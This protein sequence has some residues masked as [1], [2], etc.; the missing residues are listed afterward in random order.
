MAQLTTALT[1]A[2]PGDVIVLANGTYNGA[3]AVSRNGTAANPVY[4]RGQNRDGVIINAT[5]ATYG[6]S[7]RGANV[8]IENLTI[9]DSSWGML[10]QDTNNVVVRGL[11]IMGTT[12][13]IDARAGVNRNYTICD[14]LLEGTARIWPDNAGPWNYEGI[15][16]SGEGHVVCHNTLSGF[17]DAVGQNHEFTAIPNRANDFYGNDVLWSGDNGVELDGTDRNVRAFRN[18]FTNCGN[19]CI[20]F[21]PVW[22]GPAYAIRNIAYNNG[23]S[24]Y[25]LNND[26]TGFYILHNTVVRPGR[27]F[28]QTSGQAANFR[29]LN[30]IT[31]GT[32]D[33]VNFTTQIIRGTEVLDY[34]GWLPDGSFTFTDTWTSFADLQIRSPYEQHGVVLAGLP[35]ESALTI[36]ASYQT[37]VAPL[38]ARLSASTNALD[39][40]QRLPNIN[41]NFTGV[42]PDLGAVE[43]GLP[44]PA[45]GVR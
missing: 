3:I 11:H 2:L 39:K 22:G 19:H 27:A 28:Q 41:D 17:D 10:I 6:A 9:R 44:Y 26:P 12:F 29:F 30:N 36:P 23:T 16:V 38:D 13:G 14:N 45:F 21:Q 20:S 1:A 31:I 5:G 24:P 4:V 37:F 34:N 40:A 42:G 8:V 33:A 18:R 35:F 15:V 32:T 25:K 7:I 43:R